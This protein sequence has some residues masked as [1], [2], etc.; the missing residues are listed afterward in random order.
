MNS[1]SWPGRQADHASDRELLNGEIV[2]GLDELLLAGL[3]FDFRAQRINS[4][5]S[6]RID[7]VGWLDCKELAQS[8]PELPRY[9]CG[10]RRRFPEVSVS[11][12]ENDE[13]ARILIGVLG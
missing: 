11:D 5:R 9:Q 2:F 1:N 3:Q 10:L 6:A 13:I 4:R 8:G 7:L 12:R